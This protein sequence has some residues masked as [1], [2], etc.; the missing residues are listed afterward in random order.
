[1]WWPRA[2]ARSSTD[3]CCRPDNGA[4]LG[5]TYLT[6]KQEIDTSATSKTFDEY[7]VVRVQAVSGGLADGFNL[8]VDTECAS[9][10]ACE[11]GSGP[12]EGPTPTDLLSE[13]DGTWQRTWTHDTYF[14][15]L[16]LEYDCRPGVKSIQAGRPCRQCGEVIEGEAAS[17]VDSVQ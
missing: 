13:R 5:S 10:T 1:V 4:V 9:S 12:W 17:G 14:D 3:A 16:L 15:T 8:Q 11:Q 6:I 7:F 2:V